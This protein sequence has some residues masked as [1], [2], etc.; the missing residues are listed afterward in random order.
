MNIIKSVNFLLL[1]TSITCHAALI[2]SASDP[3]LATGTTIT[4]NDLVLGNYTSITASN[5]T[6]SN[7]D[8]ART[9]PVQGISITDRRDSTSLPYSSNVLKYSTSVFPE[10]EGADQPSALLRFDFTGAVRAFGF[11][12]IE[13]N[14]PI[15]LTAFN[16][17]GSL[18]ESFDPINAFVRNEYRGIAASED[19]A[20]AILGNYPGYDSIIIDNFTVVTSAVPIPAAL[21]LM[22][23]GLAMLAFGMRKRTDI[24][25]VA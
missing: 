25:M 11:D 18:I 1:C 22:V 2:S 10:P 19:I 17:S 7:G 14:Y 13:S 15:Y 4:F 24:A 20:Y 16:A 23:S 3:A 5:V 9:P 12:L 8:I 6:F 21:P